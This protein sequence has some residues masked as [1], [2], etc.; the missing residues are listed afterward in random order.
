MYVDSVPECI[1]VLRTHMC[2][3]ILPHEDKL[4]NE[5][6]EMKDELEVW[7]LVGKKQIEFELRDTRSGSVVG[8]AWIQ[9]G[10]D[11]DARWYKTKAC[12]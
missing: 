11:H 10:L 6:L 3:A 5:W 7:S 2:G 4:L 8:E 1:N 9:C 12:T